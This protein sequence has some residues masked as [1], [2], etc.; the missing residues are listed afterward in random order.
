MSLYESKQN[1]S[2]TINKLNKL[3]VTYFTIFSHLLSKCNSSKNVHI[4]S[5]GISVG[6]YEKRA[7]LSDGIHHLPFQAGEWVNL[8]C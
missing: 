1:S 2:E 4:I 6:Q 3:N 7:I 5:C 8:T